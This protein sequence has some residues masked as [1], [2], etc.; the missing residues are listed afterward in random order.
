MFSSLIISLCAAMLSLLLSLPIAFLY[1]NLK[2][3]N[4]GKR[5]ALL[6]VG[7]TLILVVPPLTLGMGLFLVLRAYSNLFEFGIYL[8]ILVNGMLAVPFLIRILQPAIHASAQQVDRLSASLGIRGWAL[9]HIIYWPQI[10]NS[11]GFAIALA[12]TLSLGDM[13]VIALI[14]TQD[15][16]TLPLL[17]YRLFG[18][19]RMDEA[20]VV[21]MALC[22]MCFVIFWVIEYVIGGPN[23]AQS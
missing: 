6:D 9:F 7:S 10:R 22:L 21:A 3:K 15:L 23:R 14:G 18:A 20:A 1:K 4:A 11:I 19:Y 17:I 12:A 2:Y 8:V 13:G 16:S 5:I